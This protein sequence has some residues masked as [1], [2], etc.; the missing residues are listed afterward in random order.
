[1]RIKPLLV[2][3]LLSV[4]LPP[5][6]RGEG[7]DVYLDLMQ[8]AVQAYSPEHIR[9]YYEEV[10][11]H[12][13]KEHGFA[14]LT[15]NLGILIAH[16]RMSEYQDSFVHMMDLCTREIPIARQRN[17]GHGEVGNDFAVKEI[18]CCILEVEKAGFLPK[19]KTDGWRSA[20]ADMKADDIY[21]VRPP[22]GD[23]TAR[24]WC[25]F[26]SASEC[27]RI[28]A[29]IGGDRSFADKYLQDQL[30]FFDENGMYRDPHQPMVYDLVTR[31]Q[32]MFALYSGYDGPAREGI[33]EQLLRSA[34]LTLQLQSVTGE[35][36]YGGRSNQFLHNETFYAAVCEYYARWMKERGQLEMAA[37]FK[38]AAA[39]AVASLRYW[40]DQ[41]PIRHVKNRYPVESGY[42]CERYAYFNKYMVTM[43]SWAYL[44]YLFADEEIVPATSPEK[45]FTLVTTPDFH[46]ILMHAG[47]Y[48]V[49]L[50]WDAEGSYDSSG[51][52]R[53]QKAGA[54]PVIALASPC[55]A[56]KP[57]YT[58]DL[59]N[60]GPLALSPLWDKYEIVSARTG[61]VIL[62]DGQ[63]TWTSR[64]SRRGL[65]MTLKGKGDQALTLPAFAFDG[66]SRT[67]IDC[68]GKSL[69]ICFNGWQCRYTTNGTITP[70]GL[71][72]A[73][74]NGHLL[75]YDATGSERLVIR[76]RIRKE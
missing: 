73:N 75:R 50:D 19:E 45:A 3:L 62:T 33:E 47:Q 29:G 38:A 36:P 54:P 18:C 30:R 58:L 40:T 66:E 69:T 17:A 12:G 15:A 46:Q 2:S 39:R 60:P 53:I 55:P 74:R 68:D 20:L 57:S 72:Y 61:C 48:T 7:K 10:D 71:E 21:S 5:A 35:I 41:K 27:A 44:A 67:R 42:G 24:N 6:I 23:K 64:L 14:R 70:T 9:A 59:R 25:V 26:G 76:V 13:I 37:R 49:Q 52:G 31:L 4:L 28:M 1:M 51:I 56:Q 8:T 63:S 11:A 43:G 34:P 22:V 32:Y 16:S 65:K